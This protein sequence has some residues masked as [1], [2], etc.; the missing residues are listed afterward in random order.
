MN[1]I[2]QQFGHSLQAFIQDEEGAQIIEYALV[3]AVVSI[4]L[5]VLMK[6]SL[7]STLFDDWLTKVKACLT[8]SASCT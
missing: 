8:N 4:G 5:I 3:V 1:S 7:G 6:S 2:A